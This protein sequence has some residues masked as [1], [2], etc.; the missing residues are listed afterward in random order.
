M[1][2]RE[3]LLGIK[4]VKTYFLPESGAPVSEPASVSPSVPEPAQG[5]TRRRWLRA[6]DTP[7][8]GSLL[9]DGGSHR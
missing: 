1:T 2:E 5:D 4:D 7:R 9:W 3:V 8:C 6:R